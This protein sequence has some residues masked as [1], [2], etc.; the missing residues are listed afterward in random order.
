MMRG[1]TVT[2]KSS[3]KT[4]LA[5]FAGLLRGRQRAGRGKPGNEEIYK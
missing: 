4:L 5:R 2:R 1:Q 3:K